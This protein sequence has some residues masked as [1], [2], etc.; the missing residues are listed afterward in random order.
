M[1]GWLHDSNDTIIPYHILSSDRL[2]TTKTLI[3]VWP[4]I[5]LGLPLPPS[6]G[7][8]SIWSTRLT[9]ASMCRFQTCPNH[10]RQDSTIFSTMGAI[11]IFSPVIV[12]LILSC[13]L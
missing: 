6:T 10:L 7:L 4:I 12:F 8:F 2:F 13:L 9:N 5:C 1:W 11:P 3:M